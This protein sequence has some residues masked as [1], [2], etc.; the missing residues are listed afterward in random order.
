MFNWR[1]KY[2]KPEHGYSPEDGIDSNGVLGWYVGKCVDN[3]FVNNQLVSD[4]RFIVLDD[5]GYV[6]IVYPTHVRFLDTPADRLIARILQDFD[7]DSP[8][9][10]IVKTIHGFF[11]T[12]I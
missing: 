6:D 4:P 12:E 5:S 8:K 9:S 10:Q 11:E 1:I 2:L 7:S 3:E